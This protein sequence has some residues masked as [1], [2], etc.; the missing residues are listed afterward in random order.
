MKSF[1]FALLAASAVASNVN[2]VTTGPTTTAVT[3]STITITPAVSSVTLTVDIAS[4]WTFT[5]ALVSGNVTEWAGCIQQAAAVWYCAHIIR[6]VGTSL[7]I[8]D[9]RKVY[10]AA[11][12]PAVADFTANVSLAATTGF[13]ATKYTEI[14][15]QAPAQVAVN[16]D[17]GA[18]TATG[19]SAS[20]F[21]TQTTGNKLATGGLVNSGKFQYTKA[22]TTAAL[23]T[24]AMEQVKT[25]Y[26]ST[27]VGVYSNV[28]STQLA[29][30]SVLN[31]A[32][33]SSLAAAAA[34]LAAVM[35]F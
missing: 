32:G 9:A 11:T 31:L 15:A 16:T 17:T 6:T 13:S 2:S 19:T 22:E 18:A 8:T 10:S 12:A 35:A 3:G 4:T 25:G 20:A 23:A 26:S 7:A 28:S 5:T 33:A 27:L 14:A 29:G 34:A 24:T 21:P 30:I 1:A